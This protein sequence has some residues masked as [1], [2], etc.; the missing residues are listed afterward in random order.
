MDYE[1]N[2]IIR[3]LALILIVRIL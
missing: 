1:N 3:K 2:Q